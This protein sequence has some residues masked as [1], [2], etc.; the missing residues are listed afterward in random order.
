MKFTLTKKNLIQSIISTFCPM[1]VVD[2][3]K[4]LRT[5][6]SSLPPSLPPCPA[7]Q[8][9][10]PLPEAW[11][12]L[13]DQ[14]LR[15]PS[16]LMPCIKKDHHPCH[17]PLLPCRPR[18]AAPGMAGAETETL[19]KPARPEMEEVAPGQFSSSKHSLRNGIAV[20]R[21]H[22]LSSTRPK[23]PAPT[24]FFQEFFKDSLIVRFFC[25]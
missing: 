23:A 7:A 10:Q 6:R 19:P 8:T 14:E 20:S 22:L 15:R 9:L 1:R 24:L 17:V 21:P 2:V 18:R 5:T 3:K 4:S 13:M 16:C 12:P 11:G 25:H